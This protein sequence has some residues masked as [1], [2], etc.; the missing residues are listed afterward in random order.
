[1]DIVTA[2]VHV[3]VLNHL[4]NVD[5]VIEDLSRATKCREVNENLVKPD[6]TIVETKR[7]VEEID[8]RIRRSAID[9]LKDLREMVASKETKVN[10][11]SGI[12]VGLLSLGG[13]SFE[14]RVRKKREEH[15]LSMQDQ[16]ET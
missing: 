5:R 11:N 15:G 1:L 13:R 16:S 12:Q 14:D 10:V 2:R 8:H 3:V 9:A 6:G 4:D 7:L